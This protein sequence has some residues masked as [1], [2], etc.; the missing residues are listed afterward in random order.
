MAARIELTV[1]DLRNHIADVVEANIDLPGDRTNPDR[2]EWAT[3]VLMGCVEAYLKKH[4]LW[5]HFL[6]DSVFSLPMRP[7]SEWPVR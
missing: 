6:Q 7:E 1:L 3:G 2:V 4:D 5:L